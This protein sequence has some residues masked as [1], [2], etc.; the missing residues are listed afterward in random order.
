MQKD[1]YKTPVFVY[2]CPEGCIQ[3][4]K[5][6]P[7]QSDFQAL[8][9]RNK[10]LKRASTVLFSV[11]TK[12]IFV[13]I[14]NKKRTHANMPKVNPDWPANLIEII[15]RHIELRRYRF[16]KHALDRL[17][18]RSLELSDVIHVLNTGSHEKEK[19]AFSNELQTW[20]YAIKGK[21]LEG[22]N[23]RVVIAFE[24]NMIIITV[25]RLSRRTE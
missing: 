7:Y 22:V 4:K 11:Q 10:S 8:K 20:N 19:T 1:V 3:N 12:C 24:Q 9:R 21:T 18:E 6:M 23:A 2:I 13:T 16:T 17:Q 14:H 5:L 25:V 15:R